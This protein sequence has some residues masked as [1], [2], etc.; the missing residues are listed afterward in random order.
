MHCGSWNMGTTPVPLLRCTAGSEVCP[1][2][3]GP[4]LKF[5]QGGFNEVRAA[6]DGLFITSPETSRHRDFASLFFIPRL[7]FSTTPEYRANL[8]V[9]QYSLPFLLV[10]TRQCQRQNHLEVQEESFGFRVTFTSAAVLEI[11]RFWI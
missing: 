1:S 3:R 5:I 6:V 7:I 10:M 9:P 4:K 8:L 2:V 11:T